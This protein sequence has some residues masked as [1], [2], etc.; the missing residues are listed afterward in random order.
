MDK[1]AGQMGRPRS[2]EARVAVL[3]AV[4]DLLR[5][6]G[7]AA[8]TM[9]GIAER[10]GV[11]RQTVYRWWANKAEVL[12]EASAEDAADEL[13]V[14]LTLD[15]LERIERYL[16]SLTVFLGQSDPGRAYLALLAA[17]QQ[18][19]SVAELLSGKDP[20]AD[21]AGRLIDSLSSEALTDDEQALRRSLLVGPVLH[22]ILTGRDVTFLPI[23]PLAPAVLSS[24]PAP[25]GSR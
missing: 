1:S 23:A 20:L 5:E 11:G 14:D 3:H 16:A 25:N 22:W 17:A 21:S 7:Y 24:I 4:D 10:A 18:D 6:V 8:M 12:L 19:D 15:P 13:E 9:K 2:V